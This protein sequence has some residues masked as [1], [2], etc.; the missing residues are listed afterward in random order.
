MLGNLHMGMC[1]K[2]KP[3]KLWT[4]PN[5]QNDQ[6]FKW[7]QN[8]SPVPRHIPHLWA[9]HISW[10][11]LLKGTLMYIQTYIYIVC[12]Y[13]YIVC[14]IFFC[15][16]NTYTSTYTICVYWHNLHLDPGPPGS[17]RISS[18]EEFRGRPST[19]SVT[20]K[21]TM[22]G[23]E[24]KGDLRDSKQGKPWENHGKTMG[25][26]GGNGIFTENHGKKMKK[27]WFLTKTQ[28]R[29][30]MRGHKPSEIEAAQIRF[31]L[32]GDTIPSS[33]SLQHDCGSDLL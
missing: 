7:V 24:K 6:H 33:R 15:I 29:L 16:S 14:I 19:S 3:P 30:T 23:D 22:G 18:S 11:V 5:P 8:V 28:R 25:K 12:I 4:I 17:L 21:K 32:S 20:L 1:H 31:P 2:Y 26:H 27:L 13:I 10:N 9:H